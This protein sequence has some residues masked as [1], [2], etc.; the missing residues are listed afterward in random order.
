MK[1][2]LVSLLSMLVMLCGMS[3][4]SAAQNYF[5]PC[6]S[7]PHPLF[8]P[9]PMGKKPVTLNRLGSSPQFGEIST[10]FNYFRI[11]NTTICGDSVLSRNRNSSGS[12]T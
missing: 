2:N 7:I 8:E 9:A 12:Y 11:I 5:Q 6:N 1:K 3:L 4:T 10:N